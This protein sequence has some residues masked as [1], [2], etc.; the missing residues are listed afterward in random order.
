M[1]K[2]IN[3]LNI[4]VTA[5]PI[6]AV[7]V[8]TTNILTEQDKDWF[9]V[10]KNLIDRNHQYFSNP[11]F[12]LSD[13]GNNKLSSDDTR[14]LFLKP[15]EKWSDFLNRLDYPNVFQ[16]FSDGKYNSEKSITFTFQNTRTLKEE[17]YEVIVLE[18]ANANNDTNTVGVIVAPGTKSID[19]EEAPD[20][21]KYC[22]TEGNNPFYI[23]HKDTFN[24][25]PD[26]KYNILPKVFN[27]TVSF[28]NAERYNL[29]KDSKNNGLKITSDYF[30]VGTTT[31]VGD[32][33]KIN[34]RILPEFD[35][36]YGFN[37]F[38]DRS[39]GF[40]DYNASYCNFLQGKKML[41]RVLYDLALEVY[42]SLNSLYGDDQ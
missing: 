39:I 33:E 41:K 5:T 35:P 14:S 28:S 20:F 29:L 16:Y 15:Q 27:H 32:V 23:I 25:E 17:F 19:G 42:L 3:L 36:L 18:S 4:A 24:G 40:Y 2:I 1:G 10:R 13:I 34:T 37:L 22:V 30:A 9:M 21:L 11:N 6:A 26:E 12:I 7:A 8:P 38:G 31:D